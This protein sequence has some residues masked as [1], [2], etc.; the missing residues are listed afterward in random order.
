MPWFT[1]TPSSLQQEIMESYQ[2]HNTQG[3][4]PLA[5]EDAIALHYVKTM[6][7][8]DLVQDVLAVTNFPRA[9]TVARPF[10][11]HETRVNAVH[12]FLRRWAKGQFRDPTSP[13]HFNIEKVR[14]IRLLVTSMVY[15]IDDYLSKAT[16][17]FLP[18]AYRR[19]PVWSVLFNNHRQEELKAEATFLDQSHLSKAERRRILQ[20]FLRYE[21][22]CQVFGPMGDAVLAV[23]G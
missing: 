14:K 9:R 16:S 1:T 22:L 7:D 17:D 8:K 11:H 20:A 10:Q 6:L 4:P 5:D 2:T 3:Y 13:Q 21:L 18:R 23:I 12:R 15:Y 19:L